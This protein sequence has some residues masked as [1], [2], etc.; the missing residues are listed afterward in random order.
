MV[1]EQIAN[2]WGVKAFDGSSPS[3]VAK[4]GLLAKRLCTCLAR[5]LKGVQL[6]Y[7]PPVKKFYHS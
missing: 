7:G 3:I 6:S 4:Y 1:S 5:K 2:L